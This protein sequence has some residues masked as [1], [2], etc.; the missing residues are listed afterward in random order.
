MRQTILPQVAWDMSKEEAGDIAY[1]ISM[2]KRSAIGHL[3]FQKQDIR[4]CLRR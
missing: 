3:T 4:I 2:L 1:P